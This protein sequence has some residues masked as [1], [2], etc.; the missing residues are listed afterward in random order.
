MSHIDG[1]G[2][3][4][5]GALP[6]LV[7]ASLALAACGS[8]SSNTTASGASRTTA[9]AAAGAT[10]STAATTTT[11]PSASKSAAG[12]SAEA[13]GTFAAAIRACVRNRK[14][15]DLPGGELPGGVH[16]KGKVGAPVK[17]PTQPKGSSIPQTKATLIAPKGLAGS[18]PKATPGESFL[19]CLRENGVNIP[20]TTGTSASTVNTDTPAFKAAEA[21]CIVD[22]E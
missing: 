10:A 12:K 20:T 2:H 9:S 11:A 3:T 1:N 21:K 18:Q 22:L 19:A 4:R 7:L 16:L 8:S 14:K 15:C 6:A 17:N 13:G 5:V